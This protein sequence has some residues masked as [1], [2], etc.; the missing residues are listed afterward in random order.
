MCG[1]DGTAAEDVTNADLDAE[2]VAHGDIVQLS[3]LD[4]F[5]NLTLKSIAVFTLGQ[6][7]HYAAASTKVSA[8]PP[9]YILKVGWTCF[10]AP[11]TTCLSDE[12]RL[13]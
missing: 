1:G 5:H 8:R 2:L 13:G 7:A 4:T 9:S 12:V 10:T 6:Q 11:S 3:F